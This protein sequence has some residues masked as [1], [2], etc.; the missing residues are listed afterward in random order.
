MPVGHLYTKDDKKQ[1]YYHTNVCEFIL[2]QLWPKKHDRKTPWP[3]FN[4]KNG[5]NTL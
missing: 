1:N 2:L 3:N 4:R 5:A